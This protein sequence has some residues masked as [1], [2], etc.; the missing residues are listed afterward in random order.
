MAAMFGG[1]GEPDPDMKRMAEAMVGDMPLRALAMFSPDM[2]PAML[3]GI[4]AGANSAL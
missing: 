3:D 4:I 1:S 2:S